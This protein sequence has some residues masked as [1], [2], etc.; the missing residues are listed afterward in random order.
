M[1]LKTHL[2]IDHSLCGEVILLK[3]GYAK[4]ELKTT[5]LMRADEQGL[6]HGGFCFGAADFAAM[7]AVNNPFVVLA[8][9]SS[10]FLAPIRVGEVVSFEANVVESDGRKFLVEVIGKVGIKDVFRGEFTTVVLKNHIF[11]L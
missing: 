5:E 2:K 1:Q 9:S 11:D 7:C 8:G 10:K 3:D 6:I 4:I